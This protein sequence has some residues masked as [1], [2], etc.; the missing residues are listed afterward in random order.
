VKQW[1]FTFLL[2]EKELTDE[3]SEFNKLKSSRKFTALR[4]E[5]TSRAATA[6]HGVLN[7]VFDDPPP[8]LAMITMLRAGLKNEIHFI[9]DDQPIDIRIGIEEKPCTV[10]KNHPDFKN[11]NGTNAWM[12]DPAATPAVCPTPSEDVKKVKTQVDESEHG[13]HVAGLIGARENT[14]APGLVPT[15]QLFLVDATDATTISTAVDNAVARGVFIFNFS[16]GNLDNDEPIQ[17]AIEGRWAKR[18]FVIAVDNDGTDLAKT[19]KPPVS[20]M[21]N[22]KN[23]I[24]GVGSSIG[25][26]GSQYM[27]GDWEGP[28]SSLEPGSSYGK[29]Y[30]QLI[31]PGHSIYSTIPGNAYGP[32]TGTSFAA[33]QV[34]AAAA[35][36]FGGAGITDPAEI[37]ARLIYT[38]DWFEQ[39][40]GKV[41]GG[42]LNVKR[43]VWEPKRNLLTTESAPAVIDAIKLD[44]NNMTELTIKGGML[45]ESAGSDKPLTSDIK[46]SF[47]NVLRITR[48]HNLSY[49]VIYLDNNRQVQIVL[50]AATISGTVPCE[51]V[52]QWNGPVFSNSNCSKYGARLDASQLL[53]YV[54]RSPS[55]IR[56]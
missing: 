10:D 27:L 52:E 31:A 47:E 53:D 37:K 14:T 42:F 35:M 11:Q 23:N 44:P 18:L 43:A 32:A 33:P 56:F 16:F 2:S 39:L 50:N 48:R 8:T 3:G 21:D 9:S 29:T 1:Q 34:T 30:V 38:S 22:I 20:W 19:K 6:L 13:T 5:E 15:A 25:A 28:D 41:W 17:T 54:A 24:I 45:Y 40:R 4:A 55:D 46:V 7:P 12:T 36:L 51:T 26:K 49:R